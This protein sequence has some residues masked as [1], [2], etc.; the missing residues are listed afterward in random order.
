VAADST[1]RMQRVIGW[2][3]DID[4]AHER[5]CEHPRPMVQ[6]HSRGR[7][8]DETRSP[9]HRSFVDVKH[10]ISAADDGR[11]VRAKVRV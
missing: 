11:H 7:A 8:A 4:E 10:V 9:T 2:L 5:C 3:V 1:I 6:H